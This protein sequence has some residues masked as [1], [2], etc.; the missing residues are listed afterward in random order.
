MPL[1]I[2]P[3]AEKLLVDVPFGRF[4][5]SSDLGALIDCDISPLIIYLLVEKPLADVPF[6]PIFR[7]FPLGR[8]IYPCKRS[9]ATE[10]PVVIRK[11]AK[12]G[13]PAIVS[14]PKTTIFGVQ[15]FF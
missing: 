4:G 15:F 3:L 5:A 14:V 11:L 8:L 13:L 2:Y 12:T 7:F 10:K 1:V 6:W 9:E